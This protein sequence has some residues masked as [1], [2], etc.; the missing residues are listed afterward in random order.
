GNISYGRICIRL[1]RFGAPA[2]AERERERLDI[3]T[4]RTAIDRGVN[5]LHDRIAA[6]QQVIRQGAVELAPA[7]AHSA[8]DM[9]TGM[10]DAPNLLEAKHPRRPF[11][12]VHGTKDRVDMLATAL[13]AW[14]KRLQ[15]QQPFAQD[16][17]VLGRLVTELAVECR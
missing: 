3:D 12:R 4:G 13:G 17:D 11:D 8:E 5:Q 7:L 2:A 1:G 15:H 16:A 6:A 14:P 10:R 9:L